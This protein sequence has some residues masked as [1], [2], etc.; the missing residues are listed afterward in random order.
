MVVAMDEC[1][2]GWPG[3]RLN[4]TVARMAAMGGRAVDMVVVSTRVGRGTLARQKIYLYL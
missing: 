1:G 2:L 4:R 3:D